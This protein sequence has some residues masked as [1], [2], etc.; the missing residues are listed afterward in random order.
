MMTPFGPGS[1]YLTRTD[2]SNATPMNIGYAQEFTLNLDPETKYLYGQNQLPLAVARGTVKAT[3]KVKAA[4]LSGN[5]L[6]A[7]FLGATAVSG[8]LILAQSEAGAVPAATPYTVV[9]ANTSNFDQ[10]KGV[11]YAAT[12]LP[13]QLVASNPTTGQYAV[14]ASGTYSF[15]AGDA[16][17]GVLLNYSYKA[18]S[19]GQT[20]P[21]NNQLVGQTTTFQIDYATTNGG[22]PL[23]VRMYKGILDK[24]GLSFKLSDFMVPEF[25]IVFACNAA[26]QLGNIYLGEVS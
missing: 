7:M 25:D 4:V 5:A 20:L 6:N 2:I 17:K 8:S 12:G 13:L 16:G 15:A 11:V 24:L 23:V 3:A 9:A 19:A 18:A 26:G 22:V 1:L 10:D 14:S 21:I